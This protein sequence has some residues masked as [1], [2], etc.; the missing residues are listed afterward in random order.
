MSRKA[1]PPVGAD[2]QPYAPQQPY[3]QDLLTRAGHQMQGAPPQYYQGGLVAGRNPA[4]DWASNYTLNAAKG[5]LQG[6]ANRADSSA[7]FGLNAMDLKNNPYVG[8]YAAAA[9]RPITD[10]LMESIIPQLRLNAAGGG[11]AGSSRAGIAEGLA[12]GKATQQIADQSAGIYNNA[13]SQG[14]DTYGKTLSLLP[15]LQQMQLVPGMAASAVGENQRAFDQ[16][17]IDAAKGK[18][19]YEQMAPW[20]QLAM[21]QGLIQGNYGG[22]TTPIQ[23][24]GSPWYL[25]TLD[26]LGGVF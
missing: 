7:N 24:S 26:P 17:N 4:E 20:L 18:W 23:D 19:D 15:Q 22:R 13:Y 3:I 11:Q 16:H 9:A 10:N 2:V 5:S 1:P 25:R 21:Y 14:L 12:S 8:D 6:D